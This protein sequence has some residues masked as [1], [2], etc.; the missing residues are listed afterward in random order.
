MGTM[1]LVGTDAERIVAAVERLRGERR[2]LRKMAR[3]CLPFGDGRS[4][5]RIAQL[6]LAY[7]AEMAAAQR[8]CRA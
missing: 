5:P 6:C 1:E 7:V 4:A 8:S 2:L 3:P